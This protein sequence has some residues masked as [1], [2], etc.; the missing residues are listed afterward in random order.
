MDF[1]L[2]THKLCYDVETADGT[3]SILRNI[4]LN[5]QRG[6]SVAIVGA[7]GSGKSTLLSIIAGLEQASSG[8]VKIDRTE[9]ISMTEEQRA[10]IRKRHVAFVFQNFQLLLGLN[11]L[12]NVAL[13]LEVNKQKNALEKARHFLERVGLSERLNHMPNQLSGGEQQRVALARAFACEAPIIFADEPT[14]NLDSRTGQTI[15][16]MLFEINKEQATTLVLVTHSDSLAQRCDRVLTMSD[17]TLVASDS[18]EHNHKIQ[19]E[20]A[21]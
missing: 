14:G 18:Q 7:S 9:I 6:E 5:I 21:L 17:G 20:A 15:A 2:S 19:V 3:L 11:A 10:E 12:E 1:I 4:E 8:S 16:D 13:P